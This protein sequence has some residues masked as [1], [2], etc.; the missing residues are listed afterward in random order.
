LKKD[1]TTPPSPFVLPAP[2]VTTAADAGCDRRKGTALDEDWEEAAIDDGSEGP[3]TV[4]LWGLEAGLWRAWRY[5]DTSSTD[6]AKTLLAQYGIAYLA[7]SITL[8]IISFGT[9]WFLVSGGVDVPGLLGRLGIDASSTAETAGT[10]AIAYLAHKVALLLRFPLTLVLTPVVARCL[11][12]G[13]DA[14]GG[15]GDGTRRC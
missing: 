6:V 13:P 3:A 8:S 2:S 14:R 7:T 1:E 9:F 11:R 10:F 5:G 15:S 4:Q 12:Q